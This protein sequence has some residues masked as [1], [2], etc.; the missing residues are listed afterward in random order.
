[1]CQGDEV[2]EVPESMRLDVERKAQKLLDKVRQ[3]VRADVERTAQE[4][5][6]RRDELKTELGGVEQELAVA[7]AWLGEPRNQVT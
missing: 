7:E 3:R 6:R 2:H 1:M 4:L 5:R